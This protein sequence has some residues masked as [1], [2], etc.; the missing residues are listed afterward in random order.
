MEQP[1]TVLITGASRGIG[2]ACARRFARA[3]DRVAINYNRSQEAAHALAEELRA[4]GADAALFQGDVGDTGQVNQMVDNV[5]DKFCQLDILVCNAG[6]AKQQ[7]FTDIT[8]EDWHSCF[9]VNVDGVFR[10][11]RAVLPH[12]IHRKQ[13]RIITMSS[14]WGLTGGSCEVAYSAAKAAVIGLTKALAKE[15][16]PSGITVNCVAPG[17]ID[18]EMNHNLTPDDLEALR[19]DTPLETIGRPEDAAESVFF[20]A[21]EGGRFLTGQVI[22]PN[23]GIL[24]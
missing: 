20:L 15:V 4:M 6:A 11:C 5:L 13:G 1:R 18:T 22:S 3:G 19:M 8:D 16:G 2:A 14:I 10:C 23:G 24:I 7:L 21:S 17:V 12:F 9:Q